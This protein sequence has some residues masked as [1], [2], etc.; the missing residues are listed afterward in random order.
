MEEARIS[1]LSPLSLLLPSCPGSAE[2]DK[3]STVIIFTAYSRPKSECI[4]VMAVYASVAG[5]YK[6]SGR[7]NGDSE[8]SFLES[9]RWPEEPL[10]D[11]QLVLTAPSGRHP[12]WMQAPSTLKTGQ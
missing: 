8:S 11:Y 1:S 7:E 5:T 6:L 3:F 12:G 4:A 9:V 10:A 2:E